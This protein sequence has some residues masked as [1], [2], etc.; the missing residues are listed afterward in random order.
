MIEL[1]KNQYRI[2]KD[3]S[4]SKSIR[5]KN[6]PE[7]DIAD[8]EFLNSK[9]LILIKSTTVI[10]KSIPWPHMY[11]RRSFAIIL[12]AGNAY[13]DSHKQTSF[14]FYLPF[15]I[16]TLISLIALGFSFIALLVSI[17]ALRY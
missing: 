12:P 6:I 8:Y 9:G 15:S 7:C 5:Y 10:D 11:D 3:L 2:L 17:Q 16:S 1:S 14:R 4:I 13:I